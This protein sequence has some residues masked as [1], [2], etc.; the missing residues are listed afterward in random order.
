MNTK[1]LEA[2]YSLVEVSNFI[3]AR[4]VTSGKMARHGKRNRKN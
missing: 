1:D 3:T 4:E 2:Y